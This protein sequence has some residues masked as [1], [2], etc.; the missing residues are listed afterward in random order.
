MEFKP[1]GRC[2]EPGCG[3]GHLPGFL[4]PVGIEIC[5]IPSFADIVIDGEYRTAIRFAVEPQGAACAI[6]PSSMRPRFIRGFA[7]SNVFEELVSAS[8]L[9]LPDEQARFRAG[10]RHEG[11]GSLP[12]ETIEEADIVVFMTCCVRGLPTRG[13]TGRSPPPEEHPPCATARPRQ[14][15][16]SP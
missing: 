11:L 5:C 14:S 3:R 6:A 16:T 7:M 13:S 15:A 10:R 1:W 9:R 12:V 2:G 4:S 8:T